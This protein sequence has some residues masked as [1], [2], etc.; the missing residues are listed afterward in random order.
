MGLWDWLGRVV[1]RLRG[2]PAQ[3]QRSLLP[4]A[5]SGVALTPDEALSIGAVWACVDVMAKALAS[6]RWNI[7]LPKPGGRRELLENDPA[8]WLLNTRPNPEMTAIALREALLYV[9]I[10]FGNAYAEIV[11]NNASRVA[12]LWPLEHD[13]V[14]PRR[15]RETGKMFYEYVQPNGEHVELPPERVFHLRGPGLNGLMGDNLIARAAKALSVT[16]AQERYAASFFGRGAQPSGV[17]EF[18]GT[19]G[20]D[21]YK[22]LQDEW[23][24]NRVGPE[25]AHRPLILEAGMKFQPLSVEPQKSQMVESRQ[26]SVEEICRWFGVPPHKIQHLLRATYSNIEHSSLEFV[27]DALTPWARRLEQEADF[28]LFRQDRGPWKFT[29]IDTA[30]LSYG[31]AYSRAQ[32]QA[33]WRQNGIMTANEIRAREGLNDAGPDGDVLLVQSNMTTIEALLDPPEPPPAP[34]LPA[35]DEEEQ[36]DDQGEPEALVREAVVA[37]FAGAFDRYSKRLTRAKAELERRHAAADAARL[38]GIERKKLRGY[39]AA[40]CVAPMRIALKA[41]LVRDADIDQWAS[42]LDAGEPPS[43]VALLTAGAAA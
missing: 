24:K 33:I 5:L 18:P 20:E 21:A 9:A 25:N 29:A 42:R 39:L 10:P 13:R 3:L 31:D 36:A 1:A 6:C 43:S 34:A 11:L 37:M 17:L 19:L 2:D 16:A 4:F 26:F 41:G 40:E 14:T 7:Y 28:K 38:L 35:P 23:Q 15:N 22:R 12:E 8:F 30:P 27:R 32:A